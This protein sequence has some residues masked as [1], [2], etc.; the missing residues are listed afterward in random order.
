M[1]EFFPR[2]LY[3]GN[4]G[5][6]SECLTPNQYHN[7][8][9]SRDQNKSKLFHNNRV[10]FH[11]RLIRGS[12]R[13]KTTQSWIRFARIGE[14]NTQSVNFIGEFLQLFSGLG[15]LETENRIKLNPDVKPVCVNTPRKIP[16]PLLPKVKN[17]IDSMLRQG[18]IFPVTVPTEL[19][20]GIVPVLR[21]NGCVRICV[22][23][24]PLNKVVQRETCHTR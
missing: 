8:D 12:E 16:H 21:P 1:V 13:T 14:V 5:I 15:K 9:C 4:G 11:S 10:N 24:T 7:K 6:P 23:L 17:E 2:I 18:L 20:S 22:D 19:C 3:G